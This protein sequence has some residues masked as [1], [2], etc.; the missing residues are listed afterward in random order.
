[1]KTLGADRGIVGTLFDSVNAASNV[2]PDATQCACCPATQTEKVWLQI[3]HGAATQIVETCMTLLGRDDRDS[4]CAA[5]RNLY[6]ALTGE[7]SPS[8]A[9][10]GEKRSSSKA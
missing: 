10:T 4:G 3:L 5:R 6:P 1:V 7:Q 2:A 9:R 8:A